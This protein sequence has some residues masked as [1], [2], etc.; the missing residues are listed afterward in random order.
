M[1]AKI[2]TAPPKRPGWLKVKLPG[3][4]SYYETRR[5]LG[6]LGLTTVCQE[7]R[8]PNAAE[9]WGGGTATFMVLGDR[10]TR[11]CRFCAVTRD[12]PR[13]GPDP[14]EPRRVAQAAAEMN[15]RY[16]VL[17]S[18]TRD[19]LPLGGAL[20]MAATVREVLRTIPSALVEVLTPDYGADPKALKSVAD[21]GAAVLGHNLETTRGLTPLVR[22]GACSYDQSLEVLR[23][24][25]ELCGPRLTKSSLLLG[26]GE[27]TEE[28]LWA[29]K[30]LREAG[31]Q[32]VA[33][34]QYLQPS[35]DHAPVRRY[36]PP[37]TF[38]V[39]AEEA[40]KIGFTLV[41]SGPLVRSSYRAGES[42]AREILRERGWEGAL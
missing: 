1:K 21:S 27:T 8:C 6:R 7:A 23:L 16:V 10:C 5:R 38:D 3:D 13:G 29:L 35:R 34:G 22:H 17:T 39:L 24:Y 42:S 28:V 11:G 2:M 4:G 20:H 30:D 25:G 41:S 32:W 36:L 37:E 19:D 26:M 31:V 9:C 15:L 14:D 12:T 40:R 33:M 18:V